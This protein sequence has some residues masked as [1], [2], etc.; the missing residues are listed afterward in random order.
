MG[1]IGLII[2]TSAGQF[3]GAW[4]YWQVRGYNPDPAVHEVLAAAAA[5]LV[6]TVVASAVYVLLGVHTWVLGDGTPWGMSVFIGLCMGLCQAILFRGRP[7]RA[8]RP[9]S[10]VHRER[11]F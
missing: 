11:D 2:G 7:S 9:M 1:V 4:A 6:T 8:R 3:A 10:A 5:G